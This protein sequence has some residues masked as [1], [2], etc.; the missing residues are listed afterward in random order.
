MI[1]GGLEKLDAHS[2]FINAEEY[3]TFT[4]QSK[5]RF[6][7]VGIR[8]GTDRGGQ[9]LVESPLPGTPAYEAGIL[10]GDLILKID[11]ESTENMS[12]KKA[13]DKITGEAGVKVTLTVLHEGD[14]KP[15]DISMSR[16]EITIESVQGDLR[17]DNN[18]KQWDFMYD[19]VNKIGYIRIIQF[20]ETT[21]KELTEVVDQLQKDGIK[22]LIL[23][24]RTNPGGLLT[25]AIEVS[26]FVLAAGHAHRQHQGPQRA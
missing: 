25:A 13:V 18:L 20:T 14:K 23:D 24:L 15:V 10:A 5:G 21:V 4:K 9:L 1:N 6:G 8:I 26:E 22:G 12:Q 16:A 3:R 19:K 2:T 17:I 11:G 7:G